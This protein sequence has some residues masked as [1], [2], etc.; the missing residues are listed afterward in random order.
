MEPM[1]QEDVLN[2]ILVEENKRLMAALHTVH[3]HLHHER[4]N[5]AHEACEGAY[6]RQ[7]SKSGAYRHGS[8][9]A[10]SG[11][12]QK[13]SGGRVEPNAVLISA[14]Q[15]PK[16]QKYH[17]VEEFRDLWRLAFRNVR[18]SYA[19][20]YC[21]AECRD[22]IPQSIADLETAIEHEFDLPYPDGKRMGLAA[23]A[24]EFFQKL[25]AKRA[26]RLDKKVSK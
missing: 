20:Q 12:L 15:T 21:Y 17:T 10:S 24:R 13:G 19:G 7:G 16:V 3:D 1:N 8:G 25:S 6:L 18:S 14:H 2:S 26:K 11:V 9:R 5:L 4:F 23:E 22:P